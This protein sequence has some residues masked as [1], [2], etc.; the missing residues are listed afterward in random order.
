VE[1]NIKNTKVRREFFLMAGQ[2]YWST[3]QPGE[4]DFLGFLD[5]HQHIQCHK[6]LFQLVTPLW[7]YNWF[8]VSGAV[9]NT[10]FNWYKIIA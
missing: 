4:V 6:D 1:K 3:K 10:C 7:T 2:K 9:P 8:V 5:I